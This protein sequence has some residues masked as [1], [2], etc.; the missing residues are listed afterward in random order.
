M[1]EET[2]EKTGR[3]R[4]N[5]GQLQQTALWVLNTAA[6]LKEFISPKLEKRHSLLHLKDPK[7]NTSKQCYAAPPHSLPEN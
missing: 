7:V 3:N 2:S 6:N 1:G 5:W 4:S